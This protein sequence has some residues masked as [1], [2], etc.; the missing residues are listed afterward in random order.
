MGPLVTCRHPLS[1]TKKTGHMKYEM[2]H[3]N[4]DN[5]YCSGQMQKGS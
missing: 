4:N 2:T 3:I 1:W 5:Y